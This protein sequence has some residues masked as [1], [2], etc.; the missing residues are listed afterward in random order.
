MQVCGFQRGAKGNDYLRSLCTTECRSWRAIFI[1]NVAFSAS[2][3]QSSVCASFLLVRLLNRGEQL[4]LSVILVDHYCGVCLDRFELLLGKGYF[5]LDSLDSWLIKSI[6]S[7]QSGV[8]PLSPPD[9]GVVYKLAIELEPC[10][11]SIPLINGRG[12]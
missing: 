7:T 6:T 1:L 11:E 5:L 2:L 9:L 4:K 8:E 3:S 10:V 12:S